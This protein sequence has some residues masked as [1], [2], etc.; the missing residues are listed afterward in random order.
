MQNKQNLLLIA[1]SIC[2]KDV[3]NIIQSQISCVPQNRK[4]NFNM[5]QLT[6]GKKIEDQYKPLAPMYHSGK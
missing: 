6:N 2:S 1:T 3:T 4:I 5:V